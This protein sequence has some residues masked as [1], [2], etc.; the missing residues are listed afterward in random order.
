MT[1]KKKKMTRGALLKVAEKCGAQIAQEATDTLDRDKICNLLESAWKK[2]GVAFETGVWFPQF[3]D[4]MKLNCGLYVDFLLDKRLA[5]MIAGSDKPRA[6]VEEELG[7]CADSSLFEDAVILHFG[8][9]FR[10][11]PVAFNDITRSWI[12]VP[13]SSPS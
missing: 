12:K 1:A 13:P 6:I 8:K 3:L 5:V 7:F 2:A 11:I 4:G 9:H 10:C